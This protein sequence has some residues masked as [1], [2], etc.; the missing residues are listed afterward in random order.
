MP[1]RRHALQR[2]I[3]DLLDARPHVLDPARGEG[4]NDQPA[5]SRMIGRVLLKHP[6][7]HGAIDWL[8]KDLSPIASRHPADKIFTKAFVTQNEADLGVPARHMKSERRA[9]YRI[10][11][12]KS[13]IA[14]IRIG[15]DRW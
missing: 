7:A 3:D 5:Q 12:P 9:V 10:N 2:S 11:R 6:V 1:Q 8:V 4:L 13:V 14:G 15:D